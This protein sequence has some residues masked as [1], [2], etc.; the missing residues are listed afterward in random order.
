[1]NKVQ[2]SIT[3]GIIAI[4]LIAL[5][6]G[7]FA[8]YSLSNDLALKEAELAK[9]I[10]TKDANIADLQSRVFA[11][12]EDKQK[13]GATLQAEQKKNGTF[14]SQLSSLSGT[15]GTLQKL[16]TTDSELLAKYSKVYFL[17]ENYAPKRLN[18]IDTEFV[19]QKDRLL[20]IQ[21]DVEPFLDDLLTDAKDDDIDLLVASAY[22]SFSQQAALKS[23]YKVTYG[24][25][26]N[27]FSAD[28][29]YSE[30]Q[31][32]TTVDF[33]TAGIGG[34]LVGFDKTPAFT[35]LQEHA[36][37]YGFILSYPKNNGFYQ[38]EPWHW[39]FV[40]R[41][42][43]RDLHTDGKQFYDLDQRAIDEYLVTLF[44]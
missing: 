4:A 36:H 17:N 29:G 14:E 35:W 24:S 25:G 5:A 10:E 1:M 37:R 11:L 31:L 40:G 13:L 16:A 18:D 32:G 22:R 20:E 21:Y 2:F 26:A 3:I 38:Y 27:A 44:D 12:G 19:S 9:T 39:R 41:D 8:F 7:G 43:A 6:A 23:N 42:L 34:S 15:V 28:Q 33:T 30:H